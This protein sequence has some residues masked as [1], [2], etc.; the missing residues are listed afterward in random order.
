MLKLSTRLAMAMVSLVLVTTV[1]LGLITSQNITRVA[2]PRSLDRLETRAQLNAT[3]LEAAVHNARV[4]IVAFRTTAAVSDLGKAYDKRLIDPAA[5]DIAEM[6]RKRFTVRF[7]AELSAKPQYAQIRV[8]ELEND[9]MELIRVDRSGS[10]GAIRIV[11]EAELAATGEGDFFKRSVGLGAN[12]IYVS[13]VEMQQ[14]PSIAGRA[15]FPVVHV[16]AP[17]MVDQRKAF[18]IGVFDVDLQPAFDRIRAKK[19]SD[20]RIYVVDERGE[21][22]LQPGMQG[23]TAADGRIRIQSIFPLFDEAMAKGRNS[24]VWADRSGDQFLVG[25]AS[26]ALGGGPRITVIEAGTYSAIN[27]GL[28]GVGK[29]A[30]VG[31]GLAILCAI[32]LALLLARSLS[33]PLVQMTRAVEGF[34]RGE[35]IALSP[36]GGREIEVLSAA[37]THMVADVKQ[38][39]AL[40]NN[41]ITA[42]ADPVLVADAD[43]KIVLA[44]PSARRVLGVEP[45]RGSVGQMNEQFNV[46]Y[47]DGVTPFPPEKLAMSQALRGQS[48]DS[49]HFVVRPNGGEIAA[50]IVVSGRPIFD[51]AGVLSGAVT[52][53]HD[54]T[55]RL[56]AQEAQ[57]AS[58]QM[59]QAVI[60]TALD[61]FVQIDS[62]G[63]V[64]LWSPKAE[65]M[66]G[67]T[68]DEVIGKNLGELVVCGDKQ[69]PFSERIGQALRK[70]DE[71]I[72]GWRFETMTR[73]RDGTEIITEISLTALRRRDAVIINMFL[74]DITQSRGAE[75]QLKHAQKMES[76]GELTG[77]L[78]HDFNNM[79]TVI[80]GTIDIL[81]EAV[82]DKPQLAAIVA[83]ISG[84]ADRGTELTA[85]LLAFAR[86]Q[87][88]QPRAIDTNALM[89][90][91]CKLLQPTLGRQ[92]EVEADL[93]ADVWPALVDPGQLSSAL[94][95]LA[96]NARDAM[97]DGGKLLLT[98]SNIEI[99]AP[100]TRFNGLLASGSYVLIAVT[101]SGTGMP[102]A[103][104]DKVFE[105]FFSTKDPGRGTGLG[106]S[107]VYGFVKQSGGHIEA[108][109]DLGRGTTFRIYL[110]KA[111]EQP[112]PVAE[113]GG[114][115]RTTGGHETI[116]CVEDDASVSSLVQTQLQS[117][118]YKTV[119]AA[120]AAEALAL[121][122]RGEPFD[123]L[124]TDI[125]MPG[126]MNGR[127]LAEAVAQRRPE[128]KV[129]FTSGY[130]EN[131]DFIDKAQMNGDVLMLAKPY[132]RSDL[133]RMIRVALESPPSA[134]IRNAHAAAAS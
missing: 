118:G 58:E 39:G 92:V 11:P 32:V 109:S 65:T 93:E 47:P 31:G 70:L 36:G 116:L 40:L 15:A 48:V 55:R 30:L 123:L 59:A 105:P 75:E 121:V 76:V 84:A 22:L 68:R 90:E 95:N 19:S 89:L 108:V 57:S 67:W 111:I 127:Q 9:G 131:E 129:L 101:D 24:G 134:I 69:T 113:S 114:T 7:S 97:P 81:A 128:L 4:D 79:L 14:V 49:L 66:L 117:L 104:L 61:A 20:R 83:L 112:K 41:V 62:H 119:H 120:N 13:P 52:V 88:L 35:A 42:L 44:N 74:R 12:D 45:G 1:A 122:D 38:K 18:A 91:V 46:F 64:L 56:R 50:D 23:A 21:D 63:S 130:T 37:F 10:G 103:V 125:V 71:G 54:I 6:W 124:F 72:L 2:L 133:S 17:L 80:T 78:A 99:A 25:W 82:A 8:I 16:A 85:N 29:S 132:R 100:D 86:K 98:T 126:K 94:V 51:E 110:P 96:I 115:A 27:V 5:R 106:L 73:H 33:K 3:L 77:G 53:Y 60:D 102:D 26:V 107:M 28:A 34:T 87:P 43:G